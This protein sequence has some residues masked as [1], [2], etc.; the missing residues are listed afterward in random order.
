MD[1]WRFRAVRHIS[2]AN[3]AKINW[4]RHGQAAYEIFTIEHRCGGPSV[5]FSGSRK[6][7]H[8]GIKEW[9]PV[10]VVILP[11]L[12]KL[13]WKRLQITMGLLPITASNKDELFSCIKISYFERLWTSKIRGF[14]WFFWSLAA[15]YTSRMNC[16]EMAGD[17]LTVCE[18][19][20]Y[21]LSRVL[22]ALAQ[23]YCNAFWY[24]LRIPF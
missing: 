15:A 5:D 23:I 2:R 18:R 22:W 8:E 7:A 9:Y 24:Q 20:C 19:N 14:Y 1:F 13:L 10:K 21:R 12:A 4:V 6:P 17:S 16:D 3:C 11:L